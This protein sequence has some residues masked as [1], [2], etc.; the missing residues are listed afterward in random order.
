MFNRTLALTA[1]V[2]AVAILVMAASTQ[3]QF[4]AMRTNNLTFS[5]PVA[6][7]GVVLDAG[8]YMFE[9]GPGGTNLDLVRVTSRNGRKVL[10]HGFTTLVARP[11]GRATD[12]I[13]SLGEAPAGSPAPIVAWYPAGSTTGHEFRYR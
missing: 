13:V 11:A 1:G 7:P 4:M 9:S 10:F 3:A 5:G 6:L 2:V 12:P 8:V